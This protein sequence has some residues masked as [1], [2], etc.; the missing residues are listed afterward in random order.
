M[1]KFRCTHCHQKI[2]APAQHRGRRVAC[3]SCKQPVRVP[4]DSESSVRVASSLPNDN[5]SDALLLDD[6][7]AP[8]TV[9]QVNYG[10]IREY[11]VKK[12]IFGGRSVLYNCP[13]CGQEL[14]NA[15]PAMAGRTDQCPS[16]HATHIVPEEA[17]QQRVQNIQP[18]E[19]KE[20]RPTHANNTQTAS[21]E[22][23]TKTGSGRNVFL[24]VGLIAAVLVVVGGILFDRY[25]KSAAKSSP[26]DTT[27]ALESDEPL[28]GGTIT[29]ECYV[30]RGDGQATR[31]TGLTLYLLPRRVPPAII[32]MKEDLLESASGLETL[33]R[34]KYNDVKSKPPIDLPLWDTSLELVKSLSEVS[35]KASEQIRNEY[36]QP[37]ADVYTVLTCVA[38]T[39]ITSGRFLDLARP[40][41][42]LEGSVDRSSYHAL[43]NGKLYYPIVE[44][45]AIAHAEVGLQGNFGFTDVPP[46]QYCLTALYSTHSFAICWIEPIDIAS[47]E[48]VSLTLSSNSTSFVE[49]AR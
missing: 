37:S 21:R 1:I 47:G 7:P 19:S 20:R 10:V 48:D 3:P 15:L 44:S 2:G 30:I 11:R 27:M 24:A 12:S 49:N 5:H 13:A 31:A 16:C 22:T 28:V 18:I 40:L 32:P 42:M 34:D 23:Q 36:Q 9:S 35:E 6:I 45:L 14:E 46:G 33:T 38:T 4:A 39:L 8:D 29:G 17:K 43:K 26:A 41:S 25:E